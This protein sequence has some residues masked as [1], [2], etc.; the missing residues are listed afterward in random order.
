MAILWMAVGFL[1]T[2]EPEKN[3]VRR[4]RGENRRRAG[5]WLRDFFPCKR[6]PRLTA[7][8]MRRRSRYPG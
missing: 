1:E 2:G 5:N 3:R 4:D 6:P 7:T 8:R